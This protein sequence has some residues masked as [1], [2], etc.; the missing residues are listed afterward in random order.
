M[1]FN[2]SDSLAMNDELTPEEQDIEDNVEHA[3]P[4]DDQTRERVERILARERERTRQSVYDFQRKTWNWPRSARL[5]PGYRIK[6]L[7]P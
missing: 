4:A 5:R 3:T 2:A 7:F 6:H 1:G